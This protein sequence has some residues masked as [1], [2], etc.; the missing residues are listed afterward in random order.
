[1]DYV[2]P[3]LN[4]VFLITI[5]VS[6]YWYIRR[7]LSRGD[8]GH[9]TIKV[10]FHLAAYLLVADAIRRLNC[11]FGA[12]NQLL[13]QI[14]TLVVT[15]FLPFLA[16]LWFVYTCYA[17]KLHINFKIVYI[18]AGVLMAINFTLAIW[19]IIP[20]FDIYY[21]FESNTMTLGPYYY[22]FAGI[23]L[24]PFV[25]SLVVVFLRWN[26]MNRVRNPFTFFNYSVIP[27][28]AIIGQF[29]IDDYPLTLMGIVASFVIIVLD[30]Q[31]HYAITDFLTGLYNRRNLV[32]YLNAKIK[33]MRPGDKFAG[34][35]LDINNFKSINDKY[36]HNFGDKVLVDVASLLINT[37]NRG[38]Y[39]ARFGGDEFVII[40]NMKC[41]D[42][43]GCFKQA[44]CKACAAYNSRESSTHCIDFSIGAAIYSKDEG[45]SAITF[46]EIIDDRMYIDKQATR[47]AEV[48]SSKY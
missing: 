40:I 33:S 10:I 42:E 25:S 3:V 5:L 11:S 4:N 20:S 24:I 45:M 39:I 14:C 15:I 22:A 48:T 32:K 8:F 26:A 23:L 21:H 35:M 17:T 27:I 36:G 6:A 31:H 13:C 43:I 1:M 34:F 12:Y 9:R 29:F 30:I 16:L 37:T 19:S 7:Q 2:T 44:L 18:I 47:A 38:D 41:E 28:I 46:L